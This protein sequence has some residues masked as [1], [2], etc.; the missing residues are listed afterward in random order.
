MTAVKYAM[1]LALLIF[2]IQKSHAESPSGK[3]QFVFNQW[4]GK[5]LNVWAYTPSNYAPNSKI[6]FVMHGVK[7]DAD[8]YR[9]EW[10]ALAEQHNLLL[11]VPQFSQEDFPR[12]LGY[13]LGNVFTD[14]KYQQANP[15]DVWAYSAIEPLFDYVKSTY[16]NANNTYRLYGHSAG[17]QFVH[18]FIFFVPQARVSKIVSANAGWYTAPDFNIAFPYGLRNTMVT[19]NH[20][21]A[22]LQKPVVILLGEA[23]ND[24][25][26]KY[27]RKAAPAM[28]QGPHRLARGKY[29]F[30]QSKQASLRYSVNFGWQ[31]ATVPNVGH[32]NSLMAHAAVAYLLE[33]DAIPNV[34]VLK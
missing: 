4:Q 6:L 17:S 9:D 8:R 20:L 7:R 29:F 12:A 13:N 22:S 5:P 19:Q 26:D 2:C 23:D 30:N 24:P 10:V 16:A 3:H 33:E 32:K 31:L 11:I 1:L 15:P 21:M 18:R 34:I 25:N 27:L 14:G 28:R